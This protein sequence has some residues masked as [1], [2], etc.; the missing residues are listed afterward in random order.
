[1]GR[2][3]ED[4]QVTMAG[5][6]EQKTRASGD[7][8]VRDPQITQIAQIN[9]TTRDERTHKIIGAAMAGREEQ[10]TRGSGD[11]KVRRKGKIDHFRDLEVYRRAFAA[12]VEIFQLTKQFPA[13]ER[14]SLVD[15]IRRS[16][17]SVCAN[18]AESWLPARRAMDV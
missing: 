7:Q 12:A 15:Q 5:R 4:E 2:R 16:S 1:M 6:E 13:E 17:R 14:Y 3:S 9:E 10:K 11:Q 18:L 8:K